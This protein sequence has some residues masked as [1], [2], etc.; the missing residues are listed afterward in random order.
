MYRIPIH[1]HKIQV[2]KSWTFPHSTMVMAD[3]DEYHLAM[4]VIDLVRTK[5]LD[6]NVTDLLEKVVSKDAV[7]E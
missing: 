2:M 6:K 7:S 1:V 3:M 4:L 5:A